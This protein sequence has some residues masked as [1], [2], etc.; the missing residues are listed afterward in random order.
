MLLESRSNCMPRR[1]KPKSEANSAKAENVSL[2]P[3]ASPSAQSLTG[4]HFDLIHV[5]RVVA[6]NPNT[7]KQILEKLADVSFPA[8]RC[9]IA[10]NTNTP[11]NVLNKL[12]RD[13]Y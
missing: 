13:H 5:R 4:E 8:I 11:I 12:A 6:G 9:R 2:P 1:A 7:P 10:E 3:S